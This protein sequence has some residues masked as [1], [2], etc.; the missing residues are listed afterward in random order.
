MTDVDEIAPIADDELIEVGK[1][2][3]SEIF[4]ILDNDIDNDPVLKIY[5]INDLLF[6]SLKDLQQFIIFKR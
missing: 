3:T 4:N 1:G 2:K 6:D 5:S